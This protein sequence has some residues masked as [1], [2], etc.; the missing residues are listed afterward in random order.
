MV[1][2]AGYE[3][4]PVDTLAAREARFEIEEFHARYCDIL[5]RGDLEQ[6]PQF[7]LE[8]CLYIVIAR[9]NV[10]AGMP[11]GLVYAEGRAMIRDRAF[12]IQRTQMFAP[13]YLQHFV[14]NVRVLKIDD[15]E[16]RAQSNLN[17][18]TA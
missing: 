8:D 15:S 5:D 17:S 9:E 14:S 16:L 1:I 13:R 18:L 6:W 4:S 12:A 3:Q 11:L 2:P 10:E 7:F